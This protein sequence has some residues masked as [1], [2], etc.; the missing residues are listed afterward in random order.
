MLLMIF[1][2][3][4]WLHSKIHMREPSFDQMDNVHNEV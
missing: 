1:V 3:W 4:R 2:N